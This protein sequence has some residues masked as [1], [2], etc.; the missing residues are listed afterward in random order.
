[1]EDANQS[2]EKQIEA[3]RKFIKMK[4]DVI[5]IS[6]VVETGWDEVLSEAKEAG[7]PVV[8]SDR[9][10]DTEADLVATYIGADFREEGRRAM[11]W[12]RD[13]VPSGGETLN[14]MELK[15]NKGAS[16][17]VGRKEG[18]EEVLKENQDYRIVYSD[19]GDFTR[20]GGKKI[21]EEYLAKQEW[22]VD[23]IFSHN[24]DMALGAIEALQEHGIEPGEDVKIVSVDATKEAF[25]AMIDGTLNCAVECNPLLGTQLMKAVR[26]MVSGKEMPIRIITEEK[27]YDQSVAKEMIDQRAY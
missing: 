22:D 9:E 19:Y 25:E 21:I 7:I 15:G 17:T 16:P 2:Q 20:E 1:M 26:D 5:V 3:V 10:I 24:D 11:R 6:P 4:V 8:M 14:I 27:V 18:F 13:N 23:I 12:L